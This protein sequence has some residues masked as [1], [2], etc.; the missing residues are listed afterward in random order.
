MLFTCI[1]FVPASRVVHLDGLESPL[2]YKEL[3]TH[4]N[5]DI[6]MPHVEFVKSNKINIEDNIKSFFVDQ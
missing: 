6:N 4:Q 5:E 1:L 2:R 3:R